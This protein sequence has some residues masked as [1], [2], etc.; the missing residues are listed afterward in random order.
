[1]EVLA[2]LA[3]GG[4]QSV[5]APAG[6]H[7]SWIATLLWVTMAI[8]AAI[9]IAL[10]LLLL[11]ALREHPQDARSERRHRR[12]VVAASVATVAVLFLLLG[13]SLEAGRRLDRAPPGAPL[14]VRV[15]GAQ[16]WWEVVYADPQPSL[17]L[18]TANEIWIPVGEPVKLVLGTR[19][20]IHSFWVPRLHGKADLLPAQQHVL[21][22]RADEPGEYPGQCAEFC[23]LQHAKMALR[24]HAVPRAR[25]DAWL[26]AQRAPAREPVGEAA[27]RGRAL[28]LARGCALC[29]RVRGSGAEGTFGPDLT[30]LASRQRLA[31]GWLPNTPEHLAGWVARPQA[32]K[33]GV[34][35]PDPT[36]AAGEVAALVAFL[37]GLE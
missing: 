27:L 2:P 22:L 13:A 8:L 1:M 17:Q 5:L 6:P 4:A 18:T 31:A 36:L 34:R 12:A 32:V 30:H 7:A 20:V 29:H 33:R 35:M 25:F 28:F 19:D 10:V 15:T 37:R 14:T 26:A 21:W 23:G 3:L 11:L 24:V 9:W 16:W